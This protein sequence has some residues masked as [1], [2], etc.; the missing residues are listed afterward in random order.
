MSF[1]LEPV[2]RVSLPDAVFDQ[3]ANQILSQRL[4]AGQPL[5]SERELAKAFGVNRGA[6]REALKRLS[7]TGLIEQRQGGGTTVLD[8]RQRA[9]L[10]LLPRLLFSAGAEPNLLVARAIMEMRAALAPD[11]ARLC[12]ARAEPALVEELRAVILAM[13]EAAAP[14]DLD[15]LQTLNLELWELL[16]RGS[17]NIA[18]RLAFNTLRQ[19]YDSIR[20]ALVVALA[21]ELRAVETCAALVEA[22]STHADERAHDLAREL[23]DH[24][25]AG[26]MAALELFASFEP[27][28][29]K[30]EHSPQGA[31][32]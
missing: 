18:Y 21:A 13:R 7:Q 9:S 25:S 24:G 20:E 19:T 30:S 23:I 8:F 1:G 22:V 32:S 14:E 12:A 10:D 6:V 3:L 26:V 29:N 16:V 11:I 17:D 28:P 27:N 31:P 2:A 15:R 5:P 4:P